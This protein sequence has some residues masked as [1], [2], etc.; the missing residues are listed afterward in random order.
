MPQLLR[1]VLQDVAL[2]SSLS[3]PNI[4]MACPP[5][6]RL[7]TSA[8]S[9][10]NLR[11]FAAL[12]LGVVRL[13]VFTKQPWN[14]ALRR[15][16]CARIKTIFAKMGATSILRLFPHT[17]SPLTRNEELAVKDLLQIHEQSA[18]L[19]NAQSLSKE[20]LGPC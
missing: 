2:S 1:H 5:R 3:C 17:L 14:C 8:G 9:R 15:G 18:G 13:R 4:K 11:L 6:I 16:L 20:V 7:D 19:I 12:H 10:L